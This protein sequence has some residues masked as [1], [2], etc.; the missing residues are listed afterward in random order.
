[1]P[2]DHSFNSFKQLIKDQFMEYN[3]E[4]YAHV[5]SWSSMQTLIIINAIDEY[6]NVLIDHKDINNIQTIASLHQIVMKKMR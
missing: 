4:N 3:I 2:T 1:M 6:Y 5:T